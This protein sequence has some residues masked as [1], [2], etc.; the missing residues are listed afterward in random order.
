MNWG[1]VGNE[2]V[3]KKKLSYRTRP[4]IYWSVYISTFTCGHNLRVTTERTRSR[5]QVAEMHILCE[6]PV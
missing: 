4:S 1:G 5:T 6:E 2:G 3:V